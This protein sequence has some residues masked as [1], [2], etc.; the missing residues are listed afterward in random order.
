MAT[1]VLLHGS[2]QG[3]WAW[4]AVTPLLERAGHRALAVDLPDECWKQQRER[5]VTLAWLA[6]HVASVVATATPPVVLVGH[7]AGGILAS[8]VAE[9]CPKRLACL[10][11]LCAFMLRDG[12]SIETFYAAHLQPW[13]R[14]ANR[15]AT[16]SSDGLWTRID[17]ADAMEVFY[18]CAPLEIGRAAAAR[19]TTQPVAPAKTALRLT[20]ERYGSVRRYYIEALQ[21]RSVHLELQR[22]MLASQ[23]CHE[24]F[25]IDTDHAPQ[26]SRP[27]LLAGMLLRIA[28]AQ[29]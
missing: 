26:L 10:V 19:L 1:F 12:E 24:V 8:E 17:P 15:R 3:A 27:A 21:D 2:W 20:S 7:S 22:T 11:Y 14:G 23:P 4:G 29:A 16:L 18:H 9:R 6:D 5:P 25:S 28:D 13:M